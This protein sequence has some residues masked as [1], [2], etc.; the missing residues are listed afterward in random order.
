MISLVN[1]SNQVLQR[2]RQKDLEHIDHINADVRQVCVCECVSVC[3]CVRVRV[4]VCACVRVCVCASVRV[5]VCE[6]ACVRVC[7]RARVRVCV[8]ACH[9]NADVWQLR[10][11]ENAWKRIEKA[12]LLGQLDTVQR[13]SLGKKIK[14]MNK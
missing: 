7:V 8:C 13:V 2:E 5:C 9:L 11:E 12:R 4:C 3:M 1:N 14:K 6:C 10:V